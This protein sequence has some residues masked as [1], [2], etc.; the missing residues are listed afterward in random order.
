MTVTELIAYLEKLP[1]DTVIGVVY[2]ACSEPH[3][4]EE[5]ELKFNPKDKPAVGRYN[6]KRYVMRH[7]HLVEYDPKQWDHSE[8]QP[9]FVPV[10]EFPGN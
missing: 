10:L 6:E 4:L 7:G 2:W 9:E 1:K 3:I 5:R 8:G